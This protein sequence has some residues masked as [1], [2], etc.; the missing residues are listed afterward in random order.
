MTRNPRTLRL[1]FALFSRLAPGR[2]VKLYLAVALL[3]L[4]SLAGGQVPAVKAPSAAL[5]TNLP[6]PILFV[7]Q[8]PIAADFTT[9]GSTFGNHQASLEAAGRGGDLWIRY[10]NGSLKNLTA[11][12]GYGASGFLSGNGAIAVRDPSV[13]WDGTK[14]VFSMVVGAPTQQFQAQT[15]YWQLY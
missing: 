2:P 1:P 3:V 8:L 4:M 12:A 6:Y 7:T 14:A 5:P 13:Y 9:I 11:A 15:Y 10:P